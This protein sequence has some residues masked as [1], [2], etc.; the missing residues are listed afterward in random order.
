MVTDTTA[1]GEGMNDSRFADA[2]RRSAGLLPQGRTRVSGLG[3][4][5]GCCHLLGVRVLTESVHPLWAQKTIMKGSTPGWTPVA[6]S[7]E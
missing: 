6:T 1:F 2:H 7:S 5:A 4:S 3:S